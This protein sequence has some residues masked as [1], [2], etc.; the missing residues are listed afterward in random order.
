VLDRYTH[1]AITVLFWASQQ[2]RENGAQMLDDTHLL[3]GLLTVPDTLALMVLEEFSVRPADIE[4]DLQ[5]RRAHPNNA[6]DPATPAAPGTDSDEEHRHINQAS[7]PAPS[8]RR[9]GKPCRR[10]S[11][12]IRL[13]S[14]SVKTALTQA[15]IEA[16]ALRHRD[17]GPEHILLALV[18]G[19]GVAHDVLVDHG[20][21]LDIARLIVEEPVRG[22][23][24]R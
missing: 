13:H 6:P 1:D 12:P 4:I 7:W 18:H 14:K 5:R 8:D 15:L 2:A 24:P 3:T 20:V 17:V 10:T 21:R 22:R 23:R 11:G 16:N 9:R 19:E